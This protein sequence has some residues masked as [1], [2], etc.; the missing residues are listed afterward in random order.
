MGCRNRHHLFC[1]AECQQPCSSSLSLLL[2]QGERTRPA[3][4][5]GMG[6]WEQL[7]ESHWVIPWGAP[8]HCPYLCWKPER[9]IEIPGSSWLPHASRTPAL[10][11]LTSSRFG[12]S[13]RE[14]CSFGGVKIFIIEWFSPALVPEWFDHRRNIKFLWCW[15]RLVLEMTKEHKQY[16]LC[17]CG[18]HEF[19]MC[20]LI[21]ESYLSAFSGGLVR[22]STKP[23][24]QDELCLKGTW[25]IKCLKLFC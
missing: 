3:T 6:L 24:L 21:F 1:S 18:C 20:L 15:E 22:L 4:D 19:S 13:R 14:K 12:C 7:G 2:T 10:W 9:D 16:F 23:L 11:M 17:A 25:N 8:D 5:V